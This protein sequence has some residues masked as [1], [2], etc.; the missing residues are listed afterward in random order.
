[1]TFKD[2]DFVDG[3]M[4]GLDAM[5]FEKPTPIQ[6]QAIPHILNKK[7]LIACAQTGTG[8]T[9]A[10]LLPII[11]K[12]EQN[13]GERLDTLIIVPT[14]EL[15]LQIDQQLTGFS[16]FTGV[17]S[18]A[19]YGGGDAAGFE[20]EK[21]ALKSGVNVIIATPGK[22]IAHLNLGYVNF[23]NL[24][25]VILDEADRMLDMGFYEDIT[26][27][28]RKCPKERQNLMFSA[29][30]PPKIRQFAKNILVDPEEISI[31]ISKPAKGVLQGAYL[32]HNHQKVKLIQ[33]L[34]KGK[35]EEYKS[36]IIFS[37][38]KRGVK[39]ITHALQKIN[40]RVGSIHSDLQQ[41]E[42]EEMLLQFKNRKLQILVGTD[43]VSRGIDIDGI[44]LVINYD[45]PNDAEDYVHRIGRT[46]RADTTGVGLTFINSDDVYKF[47]RIEELIETE[48]NKIPLPPEFGDGP[49]YKTSSKG[50]SGGGRRGGGGGGYKGK[51]S[52]GG[53]GGGKKRWNNK[54]G[55][56]KGP[57]GKKKWHG[58]KSGGS[59]SGGGSGSS[60]GG[61]SGS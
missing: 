23:E 21:Q 41:A 44:S 53:G 5:G 46:A 54:G 25:H 58:K 27:I 7:D 40:M 50:R 52:S 18:M 15:A 61:N 32:T 6:E 55:G 47:R 12:L 4:D 45:V 34:L 13:P 37:S 48:I 57:Q 31:A 11:N 29:T 28:L 9:A 43:V 42:R 56:G 49:E 10:F 33:H 60:G 3:I 2:F 51:R 26:R 17:S 14:R 20:Q 1:M 39:D 8:K 38:T 24:Q 22:L 16:Y 59:S 19:I 35:E 36:V 30:M